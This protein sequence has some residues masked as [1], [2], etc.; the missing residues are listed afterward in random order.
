MAS[1]L[2]GHKGDASDDCLFDPDLPANALDG[3]GSS[4]GWSVDTESDKD[5]TSVTMQEAELPE[6][7]S[8]M[9]TSTGDFVSE[10]AAEVEDQHALEARIRADPNFGRPARRYRR[11]MKSSL[12]RVVSP[13]RSDHQLSLI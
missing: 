6:G 4:D 2:K 9:I 3:D 5:E 12:K 13:P 8:D 10:P 11:M 1:T 7:H